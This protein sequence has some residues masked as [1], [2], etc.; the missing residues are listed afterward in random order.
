MG[1]S[2]CVDCKY[3]YM[4]VCVCETVAEKAILSLEII[5]KLPY[6]CAAPTKTCL[7]PLQKYSHR[8]Q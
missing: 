8:D 1:L 7:V 3:G 2:L 6:S 4:H 5:L